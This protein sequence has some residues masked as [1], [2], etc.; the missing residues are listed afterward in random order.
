MFDEHSFRKGE[1][2]RMRRGLYI[3]ARGDERS[4]ELYLWNW[5]RARFYMGPINRA[6]KVAKRPRRSIR[7]WLQELVA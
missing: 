6:G 4:A 5:Q 3:E 7:Q 1:L 2:S